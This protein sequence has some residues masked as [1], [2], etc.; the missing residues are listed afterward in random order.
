MTC[1]TTALAMVV[2]TIAGVAAAVQHCSLGFLAFHI[3]QL[4]TLWTF[5]ASICNKINAQQQSACCFLNLTTVQYE[6]IVM[7]SNVLKFS[8]YCLTWYSSRL[9]SQ[10]LTDYHICFITVPSVLSRC[11]LGG[12]KTEW[13]GAGVVIYLQ[14][15]VDLLMPLP[16]TV[17]SFSK[18]HIG[19][20]FL[21][22][23]HPGSRGQRAVKRVCVCGC[24]LHHSQ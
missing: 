24:V 17:S 18:I 15:D 8:I 20:T 16:L 7:M 2:M 19:F 3:L 1:H 9:C 12:R 21:V 4:L 13:W 10:S 5:L 23:A 22:L 11:W 6:Y 14:R